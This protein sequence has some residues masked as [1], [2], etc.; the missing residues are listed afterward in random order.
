MIYTLELLSRRTFPKP[1][2][3]G[4]RTIDSSSDPCLNIRNS[5]D[6]FR[7]ADTR[8]TV[9]ICGSLK[10][11]SDESLS[12]SPTYREKKHIGGGKKSSPDSHD[13][14]GQDSKKDS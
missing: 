5:Q 2:S 6:S 10:N 7:N 11:V 12:T 3:Q 8:Q 4:D 14:T 9:H 1:S 13:R